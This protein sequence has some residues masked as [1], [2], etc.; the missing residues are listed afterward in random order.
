MMKLLGMIALAVG[1]IGPVCAKPKAVHIGKTE[2]T[3]LKSLYKPNAFTGIKGGS[4]FKF[5]VYPSEVDSVVILADEAMMPYIRLELQN[6]VIRPYFSQKIMW[7]GDLKYPKVQVYCRQWKS[8]KLSGAAELETVGVYDV[9]G[10]D[11]TAVLSGATEAVLRL[12]GVKD[13]SMDVSGASNMEVEMGSPVASVRCKASGASEVEFEG[14]VTQSFAGDFSGAADVELKGAAGTADL[15]VSG[16][17]DV[18]ARDFKTQTA[19]VQCSGGSDL[20]I[21]AEKSIK[22]TV[23]GASSL[24]CYGPADR[25]VTVSGAASLYNR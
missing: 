21:S 17:A 22:G 20:R 13:F 19:V 4:I 24:G 14:E 8:L 12:T 1:L 16:A 7:N 3:M 10:S 23:S 9:Q 2:G 6:G 5:T 15:K 18:D 25:E 11:F